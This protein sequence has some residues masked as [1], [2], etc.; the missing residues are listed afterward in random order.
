M[1]KDYKR[2]KRTRRRTKGRTLNNRVRKKKVIF[3][4]LLTDASVIVVVLTGFTYLLGFVF[5]SNYLGYYGVNELIKD[6]IGSYYIA[7]AYYV[8]F[9][10]IIACCCFYIFL[11]FMLSPLK[12]EERLHR[13]MFSVLLLVTTTFVVLGY[14]FKVQITD[15]TYILTYGSI[16]TIVILDSLL[17]KFSWYKKIVSRIN[18]RIA[19]SVTTI[20]CHKYFKFFA[21]M[22]FLVGTFYFFEKYGQS[23]ASHQEDYLIIENKPKDLVVI[24]HTKDKLLI[25][26]VDTKKKVITPDYRI[27]ESKSTMDKP[28][29]LKSKTFKGG[30]TVKKTD[31]N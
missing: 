29:V 19:S 23:L 1:Q 22:F 12:E 30:L 3:P 5:K 13:P 16:F 2:T 28:L 26:P 14:M 21:L 7:F 4:M 25:A 31:N 10:I 11:S 15:L 24:D 18:Q 17:N 9:L 27:I 20:K 8:M 6:N